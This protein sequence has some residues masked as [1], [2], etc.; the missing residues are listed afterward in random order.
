M[1]DIRIDSNGDPRCWNC[2]GKGFTEKRTA[3]SKVMFGVAALATKK[4]LK[5]QRCGEYNDT[6]SGKPWDGPK[7]RK[8]RKEYAKEALLA[9][10]A[11]A[12]VQSPLSPPPPNLSPPPPKTKGEM[13]GHGKNPLGRETDTSNLLPVEEDEVALDRLEQL[14]ILGQLRDESVLTEDEFLTEKKKVLDET[15]ILF[16]SDAIEKLRTLSELFSSS[17]LDKDEFENEKSIFLGPQPTDTTPSD[18]EVAE[19]IDEIREHRSSEDS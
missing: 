17:V 16:D 6:G 13:A 15:S 1:K 18:L 12:S 19:M 8:Y 3:R 9:G 5:C 11:R 7:A 4:K 14:K 2:G 10:E